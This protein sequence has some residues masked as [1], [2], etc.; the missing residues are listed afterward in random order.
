[1]RIAI[2]GTGAM[3]SVYAGLLASAGLLVQRGHPRP[4][5]FYDIPAEVPAEPGRLLRAEPFRTQV[6]DGASAW[7]IL[8]TT[9][10][11]DGVPAVA[12][13]LVGAAASTGTSSALIGSTLSCV[14]GSA[15]VA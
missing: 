12:S 10:R 9:T 11:D 4:D 2:L 8:Y 13:G 15:V 1:M 7:R 6:P 14:I 3:G 5:A